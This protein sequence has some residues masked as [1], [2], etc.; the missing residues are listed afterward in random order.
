MIEPHWADDGVWE[1]VTIP[2]RSA[3]FEGIEA[4]KAAFK[5]SLDTSDRTMPEKRRIQLLE[6]QIVV[7]G[8]YLKVPGDIIYPAPD[9]SGL[10][11]YMEEEYWFRD[12][13][14][15]RLVDTIPTAEMLKLVAFR[16]EHVK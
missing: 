13:K 6:D 5:M 16:D 15:V 3:R 7:D 1:I 14:I 2:E 12:G 4:I 8:D 11:I 9:S 10:T